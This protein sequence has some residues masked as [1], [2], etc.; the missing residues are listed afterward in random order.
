MHAML[1]LVKIPWIRRET[2]E[3]RG[4]VHRYLDIKSYLIQRFCGVPI[5]DT[6]LASATGM[7]DMQTLDWFGPSLA[8]AGIRAEQL[9][10]LVSPHDRLPLLD[11]AQARSMGLPRD[12]PFFVGAADGC[13]SNLGA[14]AWPDSGRAVLTIGTS[15]ALRISSRTP[16][17]LPDLPLFRYRLFDD[18]TVIGGGSNSGGAIYEWFTRTF[19]GKGPGHRSVAAA[20]E[21]LPLLSPGSDGLLFLPY[22]MG[23]RAPV[24]DA[25]A[26]GCFQGIGM[27]HTRDHFHR[28][29]LEGLCLNLRQIGEA[30]EKA[31]HPFDLV[32]ADGGFTN[33]PVWMQIAADIFGKPVRRSVVTD[34][35]A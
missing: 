1:P 26:R 6:S 24:W 31:G 13:L 14:G 25:R 34:S 7:F 33:Q 2:Q 30:L 32:L 12:V 19:L 35:A 10:V 15:A 16:D 23:E 17:I 4:G 29:V 11:A 8:F 9:P 28:A 22:L 27:H 3:V 5:L 18:W 21:R 20:Q